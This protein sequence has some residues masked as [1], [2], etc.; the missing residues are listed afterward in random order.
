MFSLWLKL[1]CVLLISVYTSKLLCKSTA[2][3]RREKIK[4]CQ[5]SMMEMSAKYSTTKILHQ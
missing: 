3:Y 2:K 5:T 4:S 1:S